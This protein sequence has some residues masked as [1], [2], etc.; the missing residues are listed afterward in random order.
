MRAAVLSGTGLPIEIEEV[1]CRQPSGTEVRLRVRYA[2]LNHRDVWIQEGQYPGNATGPVLGS[3]ACGI[4]EAVGD[5]AESNLLGKEVLVNPSHSWGEDERYQGAQYKVLGNPDAGALA[6]YLIVP[7]E[8]IFLKPRYL[9]WQEAAALPLAGLTAFRALFSRAQ[10]R[11]GEKILITGIGGG[12]ALFALQFALAAG[13]QA[14]VTSGSEEK[15]QKAVALGARAGFNYRRQDWVREAQSEAGGFDVIVDGA[16]G[17]DFARL[18]EVANPGG[19]IVIYGQTAG[20]TGSLSMARLFWRQLS[21]LGTTMG[22]TGDFAAMLA[23]CEANEIRPVLDKTLP[24]EQTETAF[25]RMAAGR[26][27][28]KIVVEVSGD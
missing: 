21:V 22:S 20:P 18:I 10:L 6:E 9:E 7:Q 11:A 27:F 23:F 14:F 24:L 13:A 17:P 12:V 15:L 2:A 28:G 5:S 3:D 4:V 25:R 16:A 26:Q 19:R 8:Y 1:E